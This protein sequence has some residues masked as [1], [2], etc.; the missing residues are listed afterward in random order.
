MKTLG[1]LGGMSWES[2]I[3]YEKFINRAVRAELGG[4]ASADLIIR[5]FNFAQISELQ[6]AGDWDAAGRILIDAGKQLEAIGAEAILICTNTMHIFAEQLQAEIGVPLI[7]IAD[8]TGEAVNQASVEKVLLLGT[9][10]TME[11]DF[12]R[13]RLE[14]NFGLEVSIPDESDRAEVHRIIYEELVQGNVVDSSR[15]FIQQLISQH[16]EL[17]VKGVIAGCTEIELLVSSS[18]LQIP[19]FPTSA[20]HAAAAAKF[21]LA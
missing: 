2:S 7:H 8:A 13:S 20:I 5:S 1:L 19:Y 3:E 4:A 18:D 14:G 16:A 15:R 9:R 10:F 6:A 11:K 17:G 12:Y 21:S